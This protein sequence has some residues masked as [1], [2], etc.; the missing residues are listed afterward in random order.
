MTERTILAVV[1]DLIKTG[2]TVEQQVLVNELALFGAMASAS[3]LYER[4][5]KRAYRGKVPEVPDKESTK[6]SIYNN[7]KPLEGVQGK[8]L[9]RTNLD[10]PFEDFW[11]VY[12]RKVGK[13]AARKAYRH[14]LK[15]ASHAEILA[16][17][18]AYAASKPDPQFT[19][20]A[21]TWLNADRWLDEPDRKPSTVTMGPWKPIEPEKIPEPISPEELEKRQEQIRKAKEALCKKP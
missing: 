20:H 14:A 13:G 11:G 2:L 15:R 16:G 6:E 1:S 19:A 18:K 3:R 12:P 4:E 21:A 7:N 10:A 8:P 9:S 17:A 5:R